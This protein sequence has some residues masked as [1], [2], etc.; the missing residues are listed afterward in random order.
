MT[1]G[2]GQLSLILAL[3]TGCGSSALVK[4]DAAPPDAAVADVG[5]A[6]SDQDVGTDSDV[7]S[8]GDAVVCCPPD[9]ANFTGCV[10]LG[11]TN[12]FHG[13]GTVCD[14]WCS[15]NWRIEKDE[16]GCDVW[17]MDYRKP[18]AGENG[19]CFPDRD[20]GNG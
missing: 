12:R 8:K 11:G 7:E 19:M 1:S 16:D 15:F 5:D 4:L 10:H 20:G 3:L 14:F 9:P 6:E 17:R 18:D 2:Y 13:C